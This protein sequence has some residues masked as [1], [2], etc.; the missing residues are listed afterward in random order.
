V[1]GLISQRD[2]RLNMEI[3]DASQKIAAAI[4]HDNS[5]MRIIA[6]VTLLFL[7]GTFTAVS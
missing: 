3:A 2:N 6:A 5:N 4:S 7:P 1:Y